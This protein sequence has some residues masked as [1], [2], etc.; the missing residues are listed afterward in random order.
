VPQST[1]DQRRRLLD[2]SIL[3]QDIANEAMMADDVELAMVM[4]RAAA[5]LR[6]LRAALGPREVT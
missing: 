4:H 5:E 6:R 2:A 3:L 1:D